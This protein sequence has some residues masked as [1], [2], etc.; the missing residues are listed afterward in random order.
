MTSETKM[1]RRAFLGT[2]LFSAMAASGCVYTPADYGTP[3]VV[4]G[5]ILDNGLYRGRWHDGR[6]ITDAVLFGEG[7]IRLTRY[8]TSGSGPATPN[9]TSSLFRPI[10]NNTFRNSKGST[11]T[12]SGQ[13]SFVWKNSRGANTVHYNLYRDGN[14]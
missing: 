3:P 14:Y 8:S 10:G 12:V 7:N 4:T 2:A 13:R 6:V 1:T 9:G 11:I 5:P